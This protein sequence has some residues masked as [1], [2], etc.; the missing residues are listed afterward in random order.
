MHTASLWTFRAFT[1]AAFLFTMGSASAA[2]VSL[3]DGS[4]IEQVDF[5]RHVQGLLGRL[6]CNSGACHGS[7]Q[8]K[9]GLYLSLF[10]YSPEKDYFSFTRDFMGRRVSVANPDESLILQKATG[11]TPHGGGKRMDKG[12]WQYNV[13]REWIANGATW[14]PG[15]GNVKRM[16]VT[17][18]E[19]LLAKPG[20][21]GR[22]KVTVEFADGTKEDMTSFSEFR[23]NDDYVAELTAT[24]GEVKS[25]RPGDTAVVISYRG[26]VHSARA[27]VKVPAPA[28]FTYPQVPAINFIDREVFAKLKMLNVVPS[29]LSSDSEFLRRIYID[30][31][32]CLPSPEEVRAFL[33]DKDPNKRTKKIEEL[34]KHPLHAALWATK[35]SDITGNNVDQMEQPQQLRPKRSKMWHDWFRQRIADNMPYDEIVKGVLCAT[36][37][38][39]MSF[40]DWVKETLKLEQ[41]ATNGWDSDY[42]KRPSLDLFW[43]RNTFPLEQMGEHTAAAFLGIR[44]E[45]AQCHKH[46]FDR[47]TQDDYRSYANVFASLRFA[48]SPEGQAIVTKQVAALKKE[49]TEALVKL[50]QELAERKK[51]IE[52][53]IDKENADKRKAAEDKIDKENADQRRQLEEKLKDDAADKQKAALEKLDKD[54]DAAKKKALAALERDIAAAK[55]MAV[56]PVEKEFATKKTALQNKAKAP[57]IQQL[58]EVSISDKAPPKNQ[59][60]PEFNGIKPKALGGPEIEPKGDPR[61]ALFEWMRQSDNP[62]FARSFV[63]RVWGHYFGVGLVDPVDNFSVANPPSN[64]KLLDALAQDFVAHK[65]DIR[66]LERVVLQSR[67][68]QL[69]STPNE[70]NKHDRNCYARSYPRRMMAE[71]VVDVLNTALGAAE[72]FGPEAPPGV[73]AIEVATN[74]LQQNQNLA[75]VFRLFGRP[76]RASTCD[77][78]RAAEPALPQTLFLMTDTTILNKITNGR[79]KT[80]LADKKSDEAVVDELFLATLSRLPTEKEKTRLLEHVHG[81]GNRQTGFVDVAWALINTREFILNH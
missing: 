15:S 79:L 4:K 80:L 53:K 34:L 55:K 64:A 68:Y 22:F 49:T 13:I 8:G 19:H 37:R 67:T 24:V 51:P 17:P 44:L 21:S 28:G 66:H 42:A 59:Q 30:T 75:N 48:T 14:Q 5:E 3:P 20:A 29:D 32:G 72:T 74:R 12:S 56:A 38:E 62:Y 25:I 57:A 40:D 54:Q 61:L 36:S 23:V 41:Q 81:K 60:K 10:G 65:Y 31:I 63:N 70:S 16:E 45:C 39:G 77:C 9:G 69:S 78:E 73:R 18:S 1:A 50:D 46:P 7:F 26:N 52:D 33:A 58:R 27:L 35:F 2:P 47:W 11:Q 6:G 43:R 76:P 71:V